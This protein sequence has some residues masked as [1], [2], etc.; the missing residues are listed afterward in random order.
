[1]RN[2]LL[3]SWF[4]L[5]SALYAQEKSPTEKIDFHFE[6]SRKYRNDNPKKRIWHARQALFLAEKY[7][8][9][10][11]KGKALSEIGNYFEYKS[12]NDSAHYYYNKSVE[13]FKKINDRDG[14]A[15][16][17]LKT[18]SLTEKEG[19]LVRSFELLIAADS[20]FKLENKTKHR[21]AT[22]VSIATILIRQNEFEKAILYLKRAEEYAGNDLS[23]KAII[24]N[25]MVGCYSRLEDFENAYHYAS[26]T[27]ELKKKLKDQ[28]GLSDAYNN[29]A[30]IIFAE[31]GATD[32]MIRL[33]NSA[34]AGYIEVKDDLGI[35]R[36]YNNLGAA[37]RGKKEYSL[38][39]RY[40]TSAE[41]LCKKI[42]NNTLII[43]NK[44]EFH[45]LYKATN[46]WQQAYSYYHSYKGMEDS[47]NALAKVQII[48]DL[49]AKYDT[50][51][52]KRESELAKVNQLLSEE[53]ATKSR[54]ASILILSIGLL[55]I[56]ILLF[57]YFQYRQRKKKEVLEIKLKASEKRLEFEKQRR[58]SELK[59][60]QSQMNPHFVFNALNAIQDLILQDDRR[61]S[62]DSLGKFSELTRKILEQSKHETISV[63]KEI[64]MIELYA[65]FEKLRFGDDLDFKVVNQ[66]CEVESEELMIPSMFI[67]PYIENAFKH[68]LIHKK[69]NK[70]LTVSFQKE[71]DHLLCII[72][73]NGIGREKADE[74]NDRRKK[75]RLNFSTAAN[76]QRIDLL[77]QHQKNNIRLEIIDKMEN[78]TPIGTCVKIYFDLSQIDKN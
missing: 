26:K 69:K 41:E 77:N 71:N 68:G 6:M 35:I 23:K 37:Y 42:D 64:E 7:Q 19:D 9:K 29:L 49:Q 2:L 66:L 25:N 61:N 43:S 55:A 14:H 13:Q 78:E 70:I 27:I 76:M 48:Q 54:N 21:I 40:L 47:I 63:S 45:K 44:K 30:A 65:N 1:M 28:R 10:R 36:S 11:E 5:S 33:L 4:F 56:S 24:Y 74:I 60:L 57:I 12:V 31:K 15:V 67:Q 75:T 18:S 46:D 39:K 38:A 17:L 50:Q 32:E 22:N 20:L 52:F 53:K 8:K 51:E 59:A 58:L 62:I 34:L 73:D 3:L 16:A 72:D